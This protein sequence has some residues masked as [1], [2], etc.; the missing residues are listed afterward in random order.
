MPDAVKKKISKSMKE[1]WK[2][3][4]DYYYTDSIW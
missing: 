4:N 2:N 1:Y 3:I